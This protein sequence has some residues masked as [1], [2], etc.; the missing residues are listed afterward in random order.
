[1]GDQHQGSRKAL[2]VAL[3]PLHPIGIEVVGGF[4]Q[5]QQVRGGHQGCRQGHP[6]P[7]AA[8]EFADA[9]VQIVDAEPFQHLPTLLL[10]AP[11]V[12]GLHRL[13]QAI[14]LGQQLVIFRGGRQGLAELLMALQQHHP[15]AATGEHLLKDRELWI[16]R[17]FLIQEHHAG[18]RGAAPF[19]LIEGFPSGQHPQQGAFAGAVGADQAEAIPFAHVQVQIGEQGAQA[20]VLAGTHQADKAHDA[21]PAPVAWR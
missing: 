20:E 18:F 21:R 14:E 15:F 3:Q 11:G 17:R 6:A 7:V 13:M 19:P 2:Q 9:A 10:Q 12:A 5:Q 16:Q 1:M 4:I 8:G